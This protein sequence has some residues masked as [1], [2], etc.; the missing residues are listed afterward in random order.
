MLHDGKGQLFLP[1]EEW[2]VEVKR[3]THALNQRYNALTDYQV[4]ERREVLKEILGE[5]N[6]N[7]MLQGPITFHYGRHTTIGKNTFI[8]FNFTCQDDARVTIGEN[9]DFGPNVTIVTPLHPMLTEERR[10]LMCADGVARRLCYAKPVTVGSGCWLC[11]NVTVLPGVTIG[12]GCVIGAGSVVT[13][14]IPPHSFAAGNPC[15][16]IRPLTEAD[17]MKNHPDI[18]GDCSVIES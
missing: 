15:R 17:S 16:V 9:C 13:R 10:R 7:V 12:E 3:R 2:R 6:E 11:A 14:E 18:L 1:T 4:E 5:L 8:N